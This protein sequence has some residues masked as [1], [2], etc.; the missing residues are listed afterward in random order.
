METLL[1]LFDGFSGHRERTACVYRTGVRRRVT[2]YGDL[3]D[4]ALRMAGRL[5]ADGVGSG[6]RVLLWGPNSPW[7]VVSFWGLM[8][9]GA[10]AVPVDFASG[11]ERAETIVRLTEAKLAIQSRYKLDRAAGVPTILLEELEELLADAP[12]VVDRPAVAPDALALLMYTSG[13]TGDPKGVM[14]THRNL[15]ANLSQIERHIPVVRPEF[16][17]L[18]LLPLSHMFELMGGLFTPLLNGSCIVY[19]RTLKPS[20]IMEALSEEEVYAL[21]AVPRLLQLLK[22]SVERELG[23]RGLMGPFRFLLKVAAKMPPAPRRMLFFPVRRRFG[24]HCDLF[25]SGGA[26]LAPEL[27]R[28]WDALGY[29]VLEGYGLTE[30]APVLTANRPGYQA[31]GSAG[32]PLPGVELRFDGQ[33]VQARGDNVFAGYYQNPAATA[34]AFTGDGWF[35]TGDLGEL[36]GAGHLRI[37]GRSKEM[38]VT[39]AGIN[40]YPDELEALLN[41]AFGI[42]EACVIGVDRGEGEEVHA[43]LIMDGTHVSPEEAVARANERL[44]PL[45]R[46][47]GFSLWPEVEFPKTTTL[48]IRKFMVK[49]TILRAGR[50]EVAAQAGDRLV[51]IIAGVTGVSPAEVTEESSLVN[52][53]GLTSIGRLELVSILEQEFRLDL[54]EAQIAPRTTVAE[55]RRMVDRREAGQGQGHFR[56]WAFTPFVRRV[57]MLCDLLLHRHIFN[58]YVELHTEGLELL[59]GVSGPVLFISNHLSYLDQ[60]AIMFALPPEWRYNTA[61]AAWAEFFFQNFR[62]LPQKLW[63]RLCFEYGTIGAWLFPLSQTHGFRATL[64]FMGHLAD[65]G[66]NMLVFPEGERSKDGRLLPF[67]LGLGIMVQELGVP[68]VPVHIAGLEKVLPRD[69]TWPHRGAVT[70]RFGAPLELR[71][72]E[73]AEIVASARQAV[74]E[75]GMRQG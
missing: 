31:A 69:G 75:L 12:P 33:E 21:I 35:R 32:E 39:G 38:I 27:F 26:P 17:F 72:K 42:R 16:T 57:R 59:D 74:E 20:A 34:A 60:P 4:L 5:A 49:E 7:W 2:T 64:G 53:L 41:G 54:D 62:T 25:V 23:A 43:V 63:K 55:L 13:T 73:A 22:S 9:R 70:V 71:G 6:D 36:D 61:T 52:G 3:H 45:H 28:F 66:L 65:R 48:K 58:R 47:A 8:L 44:D 18:S 46:I 56:Q 24:R 67:R 30:C 19:L 40:V 68:V 29:T 50:G 1:D 10:V 11:R 37:K 15:V 51:G 14:L